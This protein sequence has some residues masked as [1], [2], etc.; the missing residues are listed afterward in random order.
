MSH[1]DAVRTSPHST[2]YK[3]AKVKGMFD[4]QT[5]VA[6]ERFEGDL[7]LPEQ[8]S[9]GLIVGPSG[10]G[11]TTIAKQ[12]FAPAYFTEPTFAGA[13]VI[14]DMPGTNVS[15]IVQA[16]TSVGFSSP[17]SWLKP[18]NV[19]STGEQMRVQL[20]YALLNDQPLIVFD[21]YTSVVDRQVAKMG[22]LAINKAIRKTD[23]QFIA[24]GCHYDVL[25]WLEPDWVFDTAL[26]QIVKKKSSD[27]ALRSPFT[28]LKAIGPSLAN[29][30]I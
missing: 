2:S 9:I 17:P 12:L 23:K 19:L 14:D 8:W 28:E 11:K 6:E 29:I 3:A 27:Q 5:D 18:Y 25:D 13:S 15:T 26:M 22:S 4:I 24:V 7:D 20:A 16:F 21:E 10:T 1:F 30:I